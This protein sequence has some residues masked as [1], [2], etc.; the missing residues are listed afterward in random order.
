MADDADA[1]EALAFR[2]FV[3][4]PAGAG[5]DQASHA[6]L[7]D[8]V[9]RVLILHVAPHTDGYLW[10]RD[11]FSV[12]ARAPSAGVEAHLAGELRYGEGVEDEWFAIWLLLELSAA[13]PALAITAEDTMDGQLLLIEAAARLPDWL[14]PETSENRVLLRAGAVL[15]VERAH[16]PATPVGG[17]RLADALCAVRAG[18]VPPHAPITAAARARLRGYPAEA[19]LLSTHRKRLVL[20][21]PA[22]LALAAS[23]WLVP[24]AVDA[25][26]SRDALSMRAAGRMAALAPRAH[27]PV[28]A[29]V[30]FT[31]RQYAQLLTQRFAPPRAAGFELPPPSHPA[32]ARASLSAKLVAG[33]EIA[34]A[35]EAAGG[36][37]GEAAEG[38]GG[39]AAGAVGEA[40]RSAEEAIGRCLHVLLAGAAARAP[41]GEAA[42]PAP[43][44]APPPGTAEAQAMRAALLA[45]AAAP[46]P[47]G[48]RG[49]AGEAPPSVRAAFGGRARP[50]AEQVAAAQADADA[51]LERC[52]GARAQD[53]ASASWADLVLA[54]AQLA[55]SGGRLRACASAGA[56]GVAGGPGAAAGGA[57][58]ADEPGSEDSDPDDW[59]ELDEAELEGLMR[60]RAGEG[61]GEA[62]GAGGAAGG[63]EAGAADGPDQVARM[64]RGLG[65]FM[66]G[67]A[68]LEGIEPKAH[69]QAATTQA[70][71]PPARGAAAAAAP[72][73]RSGADAGAA[74]AAG[75]GAA[76]AGEHPAE[77]PTAPVVLDVARL[78]GILDSLTSARAAPGGAQRAMPG[79]EAGEGVTRAAAGGSALHGGGSSAGSASEGEDDEG[80]ESEE[81]SEGEGDGAPPEAQAQLAELMRAMDV[82]LKSFPAQQ[83]EARAGG[84]QARAQ[85][86]A[87]AGRPGE[88]AGGALELEVASHML[89]ALEA[90]GG[91]P[92]PASSLLASM[93]IVLPPP[94]P[95]G[96]GQ[97][98]GGHEQEH[99][100][101]GGAGPG[102]PGGH[103]A[104]GVSSGSA[105]TPVVGTDPY[106]LDE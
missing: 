79:R 27:P 9:A 103:R 8:D 74:G 98:A 16:A 5:A 19:A 10:H 50:T 49:C 55:R 56:S 35:E 15:L 60:E 80:E 59:L 89:A 64:L 69:R 104:V 61:A 20:P 32:H 83:R 18:R 48:G 4:P 54:S 31:R 28:L 30:R 40:L 57:A 6:A 105:S 100:R 75:G 99:G 7:L 23:P 86:G 68:G 38:S 3:D 43:A 77:D 91:M 53:G 82:Q 29:S 11:A 41:A 36:A 12:A 84:A 37:R 96:E 88:G 2:V 101:R 85:P 52:G 70:A 90:E 71:L 94:E 72:R 93:G 34:L 81:S 63:P 22:A 58:R 26:C 45:R 44:H 102:A 13:F 46:A 62:P 97:P 76:P 67:T 51:L 65:E 14:D 21:L 25:L 47:A 39:E 24:R 87:G 73:E 78:R 66:A 17:V 106:S 92:G 42:S 95:S 1:T 33:L